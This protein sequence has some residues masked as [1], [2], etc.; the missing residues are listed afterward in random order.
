M[1]TTTITLIAAACITLLS[2]R[3]NAQ[4]EGMLGLKAGLNVSTLTLNNSV[5]R[6]G[7]HGGLFYRSDPAKQFG[8]QAELLYSTK[9][10]EWSVNIPFI[11]IGQAA[12]IELNY[13]DLPVMAV[14]RPIPALELHGG[15]YVG[16]LV[17]SKYETSGSLFDLTGQVG[18][19]NF[20]SIDAGA[21]LGLAVNIGP[22]QIGGRYNFGLAK[23]SS[24]TV[25]DFIMGDATNRVGQIY[26]SYILPV[27]K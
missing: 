26:I 16:Y 4:S 18:Q 5:N 7:F 21:L 9:G 2:S 14:F 22:V 1:R 27:T 25:T 12:N 17:S 13:I 3:A 20:N 23:V 6:T 24:S 10:A 19:G 8:Y 15:G 11:N